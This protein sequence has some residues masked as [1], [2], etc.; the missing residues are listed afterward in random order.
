MDHESRDQ[1]IRSF[2]RAR[3]RVSVGIVAAATL[4]A[5]AS[6]VLAERTEFT[7]PSRSVIAVAQKWLAIP[8]NTVKITPASAKSRTT[9]KRSVKAA[10][11]PVKKADDVTDAEILDQE[12]AAT[13]D[14]LEPLNRLIFGFNEVLDTVIFSPVSYTYRTIIPGPV[15]TGV[16][17]VIANTKAPVTFANDLLQG[18]PL[19]ARTTLV[20]FLVNSTVGL[21]GF[22]DAAAAGGEEKHTEDFGQ[23]LAVW[24]IGS[25]PYLVAP[26][27]GPTSPRHL[28]GRAVDT[29]A[30]PTTWILWQ[31]N[32][33]ER[34]SPTM[35][36]LV[37]THE[38]L[39]DDMKN[40]RKTSPD[41]Y[42]SVRDLYRQS[43]K[44]AISDGNIDDE[45]LP[46]IP[47]E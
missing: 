1:M 7:V 18:K 44:S 31:H 6:P 35:A 45:P 36:D 2:A 38:D 12:K 39:L 21:G 47:V 14:P 11:P 13:N 46:E 43:R 37:T 28:V 27:F 19:R 15:R 3:G 17:N 8:Q 41:F 33:L 16:S 25:G 30:T 42:A 9:H 20:R 23:T 29:A 22:V 40:L 32:L 5:S 34:S 26:V 10:K 4:T 24:G